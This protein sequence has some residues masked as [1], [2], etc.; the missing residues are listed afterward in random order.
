M[1]I[2]PLLFTIIRS[3]LNFD[4]AYSTL[5][6]NRSIVTRKRENALLSFSGGNCF[7]QH[8]LYDMTAA[9]DT[10]C[11]Q[12]FWIIFNCFEILPNSQR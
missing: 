1:G 5:I 11:I 8:E 6:Q 4:I 7:Q 12:L 3:V 10:V 2:Y 9:V